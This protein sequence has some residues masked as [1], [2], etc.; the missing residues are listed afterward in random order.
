MLPGKCVSVSVSGGIRDSSP[1]EKLPKQGEVPCCGIS[2]DLS[3]VAIGP[4][5]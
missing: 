3:G 1:L 4:E 2:S 5:G